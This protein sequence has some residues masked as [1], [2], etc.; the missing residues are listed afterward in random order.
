[1][2]FRFAIGGLTLLVAC[3]PGGLR[4]SDTL[5]PVTTTTTSTTT[6]TLGTE[7]AV[8][9]FRVCLAA[10]GV[11]AGPIP[12]D[13]TGRPRLGLIEADLTDP[14]VVGAVA[15]CSA[16]L[17]SGAL[18]LSEDEELSRLVLAALTEF[19]ECIRR[20]GVEGFPDPVPGFSGVGS[21]FPAADIPYADPQLPAAV[22]VCTSRSLTS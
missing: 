2:S 5:A 9:R 8:E 20:L 18:D 21:P 22:R 3:T 19:S 11:D 13:A 10:E 16:H 14:E 15:T 1:M 6:T 12:L 4:P 7:D 17:G